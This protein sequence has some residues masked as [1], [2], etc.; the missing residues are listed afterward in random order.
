VKVGDL[1]RKRP[2]RF[3][4]MEW[5]GML[6]IVIETAQDGQI[7]KVAWSHDYGSFCYPSKTTAL[8]KINEGR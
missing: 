8:E 3:P 2:G 7:I 4:H 6:G 1:V 5:G